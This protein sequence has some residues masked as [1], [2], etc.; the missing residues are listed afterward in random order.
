MGWYVMGKS[1][2]HRCLSGWFGSSFTSHWRFGRWEC[3]C[4]DGGAVGSDR[5]GSVTGGVGEVYQVIQPKWHIFWKIWPTKWCRSTPPPKRGQMGSAGCIYLSSGISWP[6]PNFDVWMDS[7]SRKNGLLDRL[8]CLAAWCSLSSRVNHDKAP[9]SLRFESSHL[10]RRD[11][12]TEKN[13]TASG[14]AVCPLFWDGEWKRNP[15]SKW[16]NDL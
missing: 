7:Y 15:K 10:I 16:N 12:A 5:G 11:V 4:D 13:S 1:T 2:P 6:M 3:S 9:L 14:D 8:I